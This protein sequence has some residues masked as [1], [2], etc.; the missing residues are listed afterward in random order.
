MKFTF[1][2]VILYLDYMYNSPVDEKIGEQVIHK[3]KES[4]ADPQSNDIPMKK[5]VSVFLLVVLVGIV[6]G[7]GWAYI[8]KSTTAKQGI[9]STNTSGNSQDKTPPAQKAGVDDKATFKDSAEGIMQ[10]GGIEGEGNFHLER[11]GGVSQ[12]VYLTSAAV[13]LSKYIGKKVKVWGET[14]SAEKA[15]WLMDVGLIEVSK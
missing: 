14:Y 11:P 2:S 3:F 12:N 4:G 6:S 10:E 9:N 8:S 1:P 15:G 7:Y 13:D 5:I